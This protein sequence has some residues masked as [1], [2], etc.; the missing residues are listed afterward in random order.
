MLDHIKD[1]EFRK[2]RD[3]GGDDLSKVAVTIEQDPNDPVLII[4]SSIVNQILNAEDRVKQFTFLDG[5]TKNERISQ[6]LISAASVG[7]QVI[8]KDYTYIQVGNNYVLESETTS[9]I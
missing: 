6:I 3:A 9:I 4:D 8:Q 7:V 2:F 1:R 5:G